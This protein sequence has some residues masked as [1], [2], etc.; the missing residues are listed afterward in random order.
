[1]KKL[2]FSTIFINFIKILYKNSTS[3]VINNG[4]LSFEINMVILLLYVVQGEVTTANIDNN[5]SIKGIN[6]PN[7]T[8]QIKI[9]Q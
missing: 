8:K 4:F 1:M 2:G 7:K 3:I 9:S 5:A 6:I